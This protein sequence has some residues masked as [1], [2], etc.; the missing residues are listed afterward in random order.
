[1]SARC[2][3]CR[4]IFSPREVY[5]IRC[6]EC[7]KVWKISRGEYQTRPAPAPDPSLP[8]RAE[9][10]EMLPRLLMLAHPDRHSNSKMATLATQWLIVQRARITP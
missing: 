4:A 5:E 7:W 8:P 3:D 9:W 2:I 10:Q 6:L 1:M